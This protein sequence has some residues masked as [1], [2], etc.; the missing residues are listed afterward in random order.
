[1]TAPAW[2]LPA[3]VGLALPLFL[4]T[5]AAQNVPGTAVLVGYGYRPPLG[6]A[7]RTTGLVG[8]VAAPAGGHAVNLAAITAA[9]AAGPDAHPDPERRWI[10]SVTA[11]AGLAL[12]GLGAGLATTLVALSPPVLVEA[13]AGLA[14]LGAL[15]TALSSALAEPADREA[16]VIT[17]V[18][19]ASGVSLLGVGGAFWGL[20]AG[21]GMLLLFRRRGTPLVRRPRT[22]STR[23][24]GTPPSDRAPVAA[25]GP[26]S[27]SGGGG[28]V[29]PPDAGRPPERRD[30]PARR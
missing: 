13:V 2:S 19:T 14:L 27:G 22:P 24:P 9:L 26:G 1:M 10:A 12:L 15:A 28:A 23:A 21:L 11:G 18:V 5:M 20:V 30:E 7:L 4:V 25:G 16:A 8:A 17:F 6:S 3:L 29:T